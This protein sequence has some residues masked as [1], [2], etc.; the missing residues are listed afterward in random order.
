[1]SYPVPDTLSVSTSS[2]YESLLNSVLPKTAS[3]NSVSETSAVG[4]DVND[5]ANTVYETIEV[6]SSFDEFE[7]LPRT[8]PNTNNTESDC[9]TLKKVA[10][11]LDTLTETDINDL[12]MLMQDNV[13]TLHTRL[14]VRLLDESDR[15][16]V[17]EG[18]NPHGNEEQK[19]K[20]LSAALLMMK[21]RLGGAG[22]RHIAN[23]IETRVLRKMMA[24]VYA[25]AA[26]IR[27]MYKN[28]PTINGFDGAQRAQTISQ[29]MRDTH[30]AA[31][32]KMTDNNSTVFSVNPRNQMAA[33]ENLMALVDYVIA[34]KKLKLKE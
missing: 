34:L 22:I 17:K 1:M 13:G 23:L 27:D 30:W 11:Y 21:K 7:E 33:I 9:L 32:P 26:E 14:S 3:H 12:T 15:G 10:D 29:I 31:H 20:T 4:I 8:Q 2:S 19:V 25:A 18:F 24:S 16:W 28:A 6:S 5:R